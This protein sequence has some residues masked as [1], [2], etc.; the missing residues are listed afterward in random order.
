MMVSRTNVKFVELEGLVQSLDEKIKIIR[1]QLDILDEQLNNFWKI[2]K[3]GKN[4]G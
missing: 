2:Y 3:R 4:G 1:K